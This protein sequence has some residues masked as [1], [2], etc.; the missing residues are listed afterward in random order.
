MECY[1]DNSATTRPTQGVIDAMVSVLADDFGN[2]SS[3]HR[4]GDAASERLEE[5]RGTV[6]R[7][8]GCMPEEVY[9]TSGGT[10]SNNI[11]VFGAAHALRRR[12]NRIV[13]SCV[14]HPSVL[15]CMK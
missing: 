10:E 5:A 11:A 13:T 3:L 2:P 6:A 14:E 15:E 12:G 7:A 8:L 1:F 4:V 9:F